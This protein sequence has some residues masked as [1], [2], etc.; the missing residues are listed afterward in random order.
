MCN[1][2]CLRE[3]DQWEKECPCDITVRDLVENHKILRKFPY[4]QSTENFVNLN[5]WGWGPGFTL[6]LAS[7]KVILTYTRDSESLLYMWCD[8]GHIIYTALESL[9]SNPQIQSFNPRLLFSLTEPWPAHISLS[10]LRYLYKRPCL[11]PQTI[12]QR[13]YDP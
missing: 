12:L 4:G 3:K 5:C 8:T 2:V 6:I 1:W 11:H 10:F 9:I 13:A 7:T